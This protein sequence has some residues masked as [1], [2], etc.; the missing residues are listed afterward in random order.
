IKPES[1]IV[2]RVS[3][4][5]VEWREVTY[6]LV[7]GG[8]TVRQILWFTASGPRAYGLILT[9]RPDQIDKLEPI[10]KR[11]VSSVRIGAAGH[12]DE[13]YEN[14]RA[15]FTSGAT[16]EVD[17]EKETAGVAE[18]LRSG[19]LS[20]AAAGDR[21]AQLF[22]SSPETAI[23]LITDPDPQ[24]RTAAI[25]GIAKSSN[26]K[27]I[28]LM[29]W[30]LADQDLIASTAAAHALA[31]NIANGALPIAIKNKLAT[32]AENPAAI[33]R[34]G[35]AM[36]EAAARE[37][38]AEMLSSDN[39]KE[40][41]AA[42]RLAFISEKFDLELPF[43]KLF[44]SPDPG[45][46]H[47]LSAVLERHPSAGAV[48]QLLE[49]LR[50]D[51]E[52]WAVRV[53]GAIAPPEVEQ[54]LN[55][56]ISEIDARFDDA[57]VSKM[58]GS[59]TN[60]SNRTIR[61]GTRARAGSVSGTPPPPL[62]ASPGSIL[63]VP[64]DSIEE[65]KK[66]PER[67]RLAFLRGA[68]YEAANKIKFRGQWNQA[69]TEEER[70][71]IKSEPESKYYYLNEGPQLS[72]KR[73][74][75]GKLDAAALAALVK[76]PNLSNLKNAP[77]TGETI[78]PKESFSYAMAPDFAATMERLDS[79]LSGVQMATVR[80]QMTFAFILKALKARLASNV[81]A[82]FTGDAGKATGIDL[83]A[84]IA[85]ASWFPREGG[86]ESR[87]RGALTLRVTDR[88]RFERLLATYQQELGDFDDFIRVSAGLVRFAGM[89]PGAA[90]M[91]IAYSESDQLHGAISRS[92]RGRPIE[93]R[94]PSL[95]PIAYVMRDEALPITTIIRPV[96]SEYFGV[97]RQTICVAYFGDTAVVSSSPAEIADLIAAGASGE[98]IARSEAYTKARSEKGEIVFFSRLDSLLESVAGLTGANA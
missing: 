33:V 28:D 17:Q 63:P 60:G 44:A 71:R 30:A 49:F 79:A 13:D 24:V 26:P 8:D 82:D 2:R 98:T 34:A 53:L 1:T 90:P 54:E 7:Q 55:K 75:A 52:L 62:P 47:L 96:I 42:L 74:A 40:Q 80:D 64:P 43:E 22:A 48:D 12:W 85:M 95:K 88:A 59:K 29:V 4:S 37:L 19:A 41:I 69:K 68:L 70:R 36:N 9:A 57:A 45:M 67:L 32:L 10:F 86:G 21:I 83:K 15:N 38:M 81:G 72:S 18:S 39:P 65:W 97:G 84:P 51:Y 78:F 91:F 92:L 87:A 25:I 56:R 61:T 66:M 14:L 31:A 5:G 77:T 16:S 73:Y 89:I 20:I 93:S 35:A 11:I 3:F 58:N 6:E 27:I 76:L 23:D 50:T 46:P 94:I